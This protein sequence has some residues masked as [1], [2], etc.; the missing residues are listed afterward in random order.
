MFNRIFLASILLSAILI[1]DTQAA[2]GKQQLFTHPTNNILDPIIDKTI[3]APRKK[4]SQQKSKFVHFL[5]SNSV[6]KKIFTYGN[7]QAQQFNYNDKK[8]IIMPRK[9][10]EALPSSEKIN[11][12]ILKDA[13]LIKLSNKIVN[14]DNE[15]RYKPTQSDLQRLF[16]IKFSAPIKPRWRN[17]INS[18]KKLSIV[19]YYPTNT[20]L[21]YISPNSLQRLNSNKII[22]EFITWI[23]VYDLNKKKG[24]HLTKSTGDINVTIEISKKINYD[25]SLALIKKSAIKI[26]GKIYET[27]NNILIR[28]KLN[29]DDINTISSLPAVININQYFPPSGAGE[30]DALIAANKLQP[31][32][33]FIPTLPGPV[34]SVACRGNDPAIPINRMLPT[35]GYL[36]FLCEHFNFDNASAFTSFNLDI[37]GYGIDGGQSAGDATN[38]HPAFTLNGAG[39]TGRLNYSQSISPSLFSASGGVSTTPPT[40]RDTSGH[41]TLVASI[42]AGYNNG[43]NTLAGTFDAA[44]N[45]SITPNAVGPL[46]QDKNGFQFALGIAPYARLGNTRIFNDIAGDGNFNVDPAPETIP[47]A[48]QLAYTNNARISNHSWGTGY[49]LVAAAPGGLSACSVGTGLKVGNATYNTD[50]SIFDEKVRDA[51]T[52]TGGNQQLSIVSVAGNT[53]II[54]T[55]SDT[56]CTMETTGFQDSS[57]WLGAP[58]AKNVIT[59]GA[60]EGVD[61]AFPPAVT[62]D[63]DRIPDTNC[64][65]LNR[66]DNAQD[67]YYLSSRGPTMDGRFKPDLVAPASRVFGAVPQSSVEFNALVTADDGCRP[68]HYPR[69]TPQQTLYRR[70]RGT[71]FAAPA[72]SGA[73]ALLKQRF[74]DNKVNNP[75][76]YLNVVT[77]TGQANASPSPAL[78]KAWLMN[79]TSY[80]SNPNPLSFEIASGLPDNQYDLPSNVQGMGR[81][82]IERTL[83][84]SSRLTR[85]Q[86]H[87]FGDAT[88]PVYAISGV[89]TN[90]PFR[91]TLVWTDAS[92]SG[93]QN[94]LDLS[95]CV[96]SLLDDCSGG[97]LYRGNNFNLDISQ[98]GGIF[99]VSNNVESIWLPS[100][101]IGTTFTIRVT[102]VSFMGDGVPGNEGLTD[103]PATVGFN[104][105]LF[106]QDFALVIYNANLNLVNNALTVDEGS[107][108]P[109]P[110]GSLSVTSPG[111]DNSNIVFTLTFLPSNGTLQLGGVDLTLLTP[112]NNFTL[113]DITNNTVSYIHNGTETTTDNFMFTVTDGYGANSNNPETFSINISNVDDPAIVSG[114]ITGNVTEGDIGD[115]ATTV[116]GMLSI[117]DADIADTPSFPNTTIPGNFGS[118]TYSTAT[119]MWVYTLDQ[120]TV[121]NLDAGDIAPDV[122]T[123]TASDGTTQDITITIMG[124]NDISVASGLF[125]DSVAEDGT[126][127]ATQAIEIS[128]VDAD[129]NPNFPDVAS[130][131][132]V[133]G[134]FSLTAGTWTYILNNA[135]VNV[136]GL[137][138]TDTP[139][140]TFT[141][142]ASDGTMHDIIIS[143]NGTDDIPVAANITTCAFGDTPV[144]ISL[145]GQDADMDTLTIANISTPLVGSLRQSADPASAIVLGSLANNTIIYYHPPAIAPPGSF[146]EPVPQPSFSFEIDDGDADTVNGSGTVNINVTLTCREPIDLALVLDF[147]GSMNRDLGVTTRIRELQDSV[148]LFVDTW[149]MNQPAP[150]DGTDNIGLVTYNSTAQ[151]FMSSMLPLETTPPIEIDA[152][153]LLDVMCEPTTVGGVDCNRSGAG[154]TAMGQG[155]T[156]AYEM[157]ITSSSPNA[158]RFIVLLTD[159]RQNVAPAVTDD[160]AGMPGFEFNPTTGLDSSDFNASNITVHTLGIGSTLGSSFL[161]TLENISDSTPGGV[162]HNT[163]NATD[164]LP[165][166]WQ[167][168]LV[169]SLDANSLEMVGHDKGTFN[170]VNQRTGKKHTYH[171]NKSARKATF[172]LYWKGDR[173]KGALQI[174]LR[175]KPSGTFIPASTN[176]LRENDQNFYSIR[177]MNFPITL[178]DGT[179]LSAEGEWELFINGKLA[180]DAVD[181]QTWVMAEDDVVKYDF[182][183][184]KRIW[185]V[186]ELV[187][188]ISSITDKKGQ[189][190]I[191]KVI[192]AKVTISAPRIGL[193]TFVATNKVRLP[194]NALSNNISSVRSN[195]VK[196]DN[197]IKQLNLDPDNFNTA[198]SK[199]LYL[200]LQD[201]ALQ[202]QL[203]RTFTTLDFKTPTDGKSIVEF[204]K[205]KIP[206]SYTINISVKAIGVDGSIIQRTRRFS[207]RINMNSI[208]RKN[209]FIKISRMKVN[210]GN[211]QVQ[212]T[213]IDK[214]GNYLGPGSADKLIFDS[215]GLKRVGALRDN[216]DGSYTQN[217]ISQRLLGDT[218]K[219]RV[220][221]TELLIETG[222]DPKSY[223]YILIFI[224]LLLIISCRLFHWPCRYFKK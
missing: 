84:S 148:R 25:S 138:S 99:D 111:A 109:L 132:G 214:Y 31:T 178:P 12:E 195:L 81:L 189:S 98:T 202:P 124:T 156:A 177:H 41:E 42:A 215:K 172:V 36:N 86:T 48:L 121:Q 190:I 27:T 6:S 218:V 115:P 182:T 74:I 66:A 89:V 60:S 143:I 102:P 28:V 209:T 70:D 168:T 147:S 204:N 14:I 198:A 87:L 206:G 83:D 166:M 77:D 125:T 113:E 149:R 159:G 35:N 92:G 122:I 46:D 32:D 146:V 67:W 186:G 82:N 120:S 1:V 80:I 196:I 153:E 129:D 15:V 207:M 133:Y 217:F 40:T 96:G 23:G 54:V 200:L 208:D 203:K 69:T 158:N 180:V 38:L 152:V 59:V 106:D 56:T 76:L 194:K 118:L 201:P 21:I 88:D 79:T 210:N 64:T 169:E 57:I 150:I 45:Y 116:T 90:N 37:T 185:S 139:I 134:S 55:S 163:D 71:S 170:L 49:S 221:N 136:Q 128:D 78:I 43:V 30:A 199:K 112:N 160:I 173:R 91:T 39:V 223:W 126:L 19:A 161:A 73:A 53:G 44:N 95:L 216:L 220:L 110:T 58:V 212:V 50:S 94:N 29:S 144:A 137:D 4:T 174:A 219:L 62:P 224:I 188:F 213:P 108:T 183:I 184:P 47:L 85:D 11:I 193:G 93:L 205:T 135:A 3:L 119:M 179:D 105:S 103:D 171:L 9:I 155:L 18:I 20:L 61:L 17:A 97:T 13:N 72:V 63:P 16:L 131:M 8:L 52:S 101:P 142:T 22:S 154:T 157:L 2:S 141:L 51:D 7:K 164:A 187:K 107:T 65:P 100:L 181:Y 75:S 26:Y 10:F 68:Y 162:T 33:F 176:G 191:K 165:D 34:A 24:I 130:T 192:E 140:D 104:E 222:I 117:T 114:D 197:K 167:N 211:L 175:H 5:V 145:G 123:L 127:I 151:T